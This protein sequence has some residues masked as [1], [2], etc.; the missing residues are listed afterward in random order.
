MST[1]AVT[2][3]VPTNTT[4]IKA[5]W[6][7]QVTPPTQ[8]T[9]PAEPEPAAPPAPPAEKPAW[10]SLSKN[11]DGSYQVT[12]ATGEVFKGTADEVI[13]KQAEAH[14]NTKKWGQD[15]KQKFET[16]QPQNTPPT[17]SQPQESPE[18]IATREW[19]IGQLAKALN[20]TPEQFKS[21][22]PQMFEVT[23]KQTVNAAWADFT[24]ACPDY[25]DTPEN[26]AALVEYLPQE[27]I[28]QQRPPSAKELRDAH[29]NAMYDKKYQPVVPAQSTSA[30]PRPPAMPSSGTAATVPPKDPSRM[31]K[32]E[33]LQE[34]AAQ[35]GR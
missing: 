16:A 35:S 17:A 31:T 9:S 33:I 23:Q 12:L 19:M 1:Q 25:A 8:A 3:E 24:Q 2:P 29:L 4:D 32:E 15:W 6:E 26:A 10:G 5:A 7:A 34:W 13:A 18:E 22:V 28:A 21:V 30:P 11:D 14:V 27:V 20:V